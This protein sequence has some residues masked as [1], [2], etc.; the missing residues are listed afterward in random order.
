MRIKANPGV[1]WGCWNGW[2]W[3]RWGRWRDQISEK[4]AHLLQPSLCTRP[5]QTGLHLTLPIWSW[6]KIV[7]QARGKVCEGCL[8]PINTL[9]QCSNCGASHCSSECR[10]FFDGK[11]L[12]ARRQIIP[13]VRWPNAHLILPLSSP[14]SFARPKSSMCQVI[15]KSWPR[16]P[17]W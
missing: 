8:C 14:F 2:E 3:A 5:D 12:E 10:W 4:G 11:H 16:E 6:P 1:Y 9:T 7:T 17:L 13:Q 15:P